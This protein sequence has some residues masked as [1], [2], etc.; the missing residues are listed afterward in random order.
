MRRGKALALRE[1]E[2]VA[3]RAGWRVDRTRSGHVM[4]RAP[5]GHGQ[6]LVSGTPED[7]RAMRNALADLRRAG[8]SC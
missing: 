4:F 2:R 1:L 3:E 7:P 5:D 8:L 6:V